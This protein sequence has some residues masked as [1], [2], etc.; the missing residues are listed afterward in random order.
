MDPTAIVI[1]SVGLVAAGLAVHFVTRSASRGGIEVNAAIGIR[2]RLTKS[3][4]QAW[5]AA[6]RAALPFTLVA[7][8]LALVCAVISVVAVVMANTVGSS[9][10]APVVVMLAGYAGLLVL[11][12]TATVSGNRAVRSLT[13]TSRTDVGDVP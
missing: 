6:H 5:E 7:C 1:G 8:L 2:T 9:R 13:R 10:A 4:Q 3:S 11:M 12:T